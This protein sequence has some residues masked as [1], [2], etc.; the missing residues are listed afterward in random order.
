MRPV[1]PESPTDC[2]RKTE[3][4][5]AQCRT[6]LSVLVRTRDE[7]KRPQPRLA[8]SPLH[9]TPG[10]CSPRRFRSGVQVYGAMC[11]RAPGLGPLGR[12]SLQGSH[13]CSNRP[14][15]VSARTGAV[16]GGI[17]GGNR[18]RVVVHLAG[19]EQIL[20]HANFVRRAGGQAGKRAGAVLGCW[21]S[22]WR[23]IAGM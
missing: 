1:G 19:P 5:R 20:T 13:A 22:Y 11:L 18:R 6:L 12:R 16:A 3:N 14:G 4:A 15:N 8:A 2:A 21:P 17:R 23:L 9:A 10:S 7:T